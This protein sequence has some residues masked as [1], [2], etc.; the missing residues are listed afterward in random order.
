MEC[1]NFGLMLDANP[2][3]SSSIYAALLT[4]TAGVFT[5]LLT[6]VVGWLQGKGATARRTNARDEALKQVQFLQAWYRTRATVAPNETEEIRSIV[7]RELDAA[8]QSVRALEVPTVASAASIER[9]KAVAKLGSFRRW[10][11][12]YR[13]VR[14][15]AWLPRLFF[16]ISVVFTT[17]LVCGYGYA[18]YVWSRRSIPQDYP[19]VISILLATCLFARWFA[20]FSDKGRTRQHQPH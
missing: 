7:L 11:L 9:D 18:A 17:Y 4:A 2:E 13:P 16:Y 14:L 12:L 3:G 19:Y 6:L 20:I 5:T 8:M 15:L 1:Y 10:F